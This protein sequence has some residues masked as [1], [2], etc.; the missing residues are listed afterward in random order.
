MPAP[1]RAMERRGL[2]IAEQIGDLADRQERVG[3]KR[4]DWVTS[5]LI[6]SDGC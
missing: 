5:G 2:G 6:I 1:E 3:Q 4:T